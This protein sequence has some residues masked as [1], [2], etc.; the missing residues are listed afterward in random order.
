MSQTPSLLLFVPA[1]RPERYAGA[2]GS[3]ADA[4][5]IDLEDA[6]APD[7][8]SPARAM[9]CEALMSAP[10][11][12]IPLLGR[13]NA[14]G[15]PWHDDD[16]A[17]VSELFRGDRLAGIMLPKAEAVQ[18]IR[19]IRDKLAP[20]AAIIALIETATGLDR[21]PDIAGAADRIAFGSID[22][23]ADIGCDH[24]REA[25]LLARSL[26]VMAA[27]VAGKPAPIDGVTVSIRNESEIEQDARHGASLGLKAKLLIH[28]AQ[29]TPAR[30]GLAPT[31]TELVWAERMLAGIGDGSAVTIDGQM[32]DAPVIAR[33]RRIR[34]DHQR[35]LNRQT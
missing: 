2:L 13:I 25:L 34:D 17:A 26:L 14:V 24:S 9:M 6:V 27:R 20:E 35:T 7:G 31:E 22:F 28:P 33:A 21:A 32:V 1:N 29:I 8:K 19:S 23:A 5:I 4:V 11:A 12:H 30:R 10:P 16:L 15:T 18:D 3:G